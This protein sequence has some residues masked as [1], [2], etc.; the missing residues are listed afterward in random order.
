MKRGVG[1]GAKEWR[2]GGGHQRG[3]GLPQLTPETAPRPT[4]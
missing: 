1:V 3:N 4:E 2:N